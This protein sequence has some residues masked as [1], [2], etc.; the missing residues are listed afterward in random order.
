M[1]FIEEYGKDCIELFNGR[2]VD[3]GDENIHEEVKMGETSN[4]SIY[5]M[6]GGYR[7]K[8]M[9]RIL[10]LHKNLGGKIFLEGRSCGCTGT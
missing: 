5:K 8:Y 9:D 1:G 7:V 6:L 10:H 4:S 2:I 3:I